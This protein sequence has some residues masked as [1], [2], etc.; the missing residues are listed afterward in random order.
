MERGQFESGKQH[1]YL[2]EQTQFFQPAVNVGTDTLETQVML[3]FKHLVKELFFIF[4]Q[5][6]RYNQ[7]TK[8]GNQ[9]FNFNSFLTNAKL[10][11]NGEDRITKELGLPDYLYTFQPM[12]YHTSVPVIP[13]QTYIYSFATDSRIYRTHR[14][15]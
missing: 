11:L 7:N 15:C 1:D 2:I 3:P 5:T 10:T 9:V 14:F 13:Y 12:T 6:N 4:I 8:F